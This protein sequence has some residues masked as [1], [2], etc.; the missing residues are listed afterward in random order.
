MATMLAGR[1]VAGI[2]AAGLLAVSLGLSLY[3]I[4]ALK[5]I[6]DRAGCSHHP[7][8]LQVSEQRQLATIATVP[9]VHNWILSRTF[10]WRRAVEGVLQ[11]DFCYQVRVFDVGTGSRTHHELTEAV[12]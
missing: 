10:Y 8:R 2:G 1:G 4:C 9:P 11:V 7:H 12:N 6:Y 5:L 3:P